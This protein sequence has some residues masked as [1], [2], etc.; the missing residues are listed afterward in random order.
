VQTVTAPRL[1]VV[2]RNAVNDQRMIGTFGSNID[3]EVF[4]AGSKVR[5]PDLHWEIVPLFGLRQASAVATELLAPETPAPS[6]DEAV[7]G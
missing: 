2:A 7:T 3:A 5:N 1:V 6:G 4:V